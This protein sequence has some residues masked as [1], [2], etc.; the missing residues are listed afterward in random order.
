MIAVINLLPDFGL[1]LQNF[2]SC[3][4]SDFPDNHDILNVPQI[5]SIELSK[6]IKKHFERH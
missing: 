4:K 6:L 5:E 1:V 2:F 3:L